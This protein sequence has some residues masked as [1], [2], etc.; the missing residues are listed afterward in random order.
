MQG[1]GE[2]IWEPIALRSLGLSISPSY[3][4]TP[5]MPP[6]QQPLS[7]L[8]PSEPTCFP[9][10]GRL[11]SSP[12]ILHARRPIIPPNS[13][14]VREQAVWGAFGPSDSTSVVI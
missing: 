1:A 7:L 3:H 6:C 2:L 12:Q 8:S 13:G 14:A 5:E 4:S 11:P 9:Q 10:P